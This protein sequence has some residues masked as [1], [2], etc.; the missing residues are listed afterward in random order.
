MV[1]RLVIAA[2]LILA[3]IGRADD[4]ADKIKTITD[5][6]EYKAARWAILVVDA[7]S[8]RT[9]YEHNPDKLMLPASV[10]KL[11]TCANALNEFGADYRFVTP[12]VRRGDVKD[13]VLDGDLILIASG[14]LTFGGRRGKDGAT[15][16]QDSDHTYANA[17][18]MDGK[19]TDTDPLF[20]LNELAKQVAKSITEVRGEVLIDDRLFARARSSGSGPDVVAPILVNDNVVDIIVTPG[21]KEDDPAVVKLRPETA[22]LQADG[23]VKTTKAGGSTAIAIDS[24]TPGKLKIRGRIPVGAGPA[25]RI[26]PIDDPTNWARGLFIEALRRNGVTVT[27]DLDRSKK[28]ALPGRDAELSRVAEYKSEPLSETIKVTLKV[29]HNLYASTLPILVGLRHGA[30]A[31]EAGLRQQGKFLKDLGLDPTTVSF[32]GGA[33]GANADSVTARTT[34]A[35]IQAMAKHKAATA[36]FDALPILGVDGTLA[37]SVPKDSPA[38]GKVHAK[39]GTLSWYDSQNQRLVLRSKALAGQLETAKGGKLNFAMFLNDLPLPPGGQPSAQG[40]VLGKLCEV[41]HQHGP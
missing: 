5:A 7:E 16:F 20:A 21:A 27:A 31:P 41:I 15:V 12:V 33:G 29:S 1:Q 10:T 28:S 40:K 4:L 22:M 25:V 39:T 34:V 30:G 38:R 9:I 37:E 36:Y 19:V 6:P 13:K 32:A 17:G 2:F 11:Y 8:G 23:D 35:L 24:S 3:S 26:H 14:D 18:L